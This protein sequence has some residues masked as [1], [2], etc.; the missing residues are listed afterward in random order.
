MPTNEL[1]SMQDQ[2]KGLPMSDLIGGP[3]TA[4][5]EAN[6]NLALACADYIDQVGMNPVLGADGKPTGEKSAR[7]VTF[8]ASKPNVADDGT[9]TT[10]TVTF[11]APML[12]LVEVPNLFVRKT[13]IDFEMQVKSSASSS[14]ETSAEAKLSAEGSYGWGFAKVKVNI[15]GSVASKSANTRSSDNSAKYSVH[16]EA[17]DRGMP[18]GMAKVLDMMRTLIAPTA[19]SSTA[20][21]TPTS[22]GSGSVSAPAAATVA[23][24]AATAAAA[25]K[26]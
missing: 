7:M 26:T 4:V 23:A 20:A 9:I 1:V 3:L 24:P 12:A 15:Q 25:P 10:Q 13:V 6:K 11:Q 22:G 5:C 16:V 18:E 8:S 19:V 21:V 2:F 14:S 17:E